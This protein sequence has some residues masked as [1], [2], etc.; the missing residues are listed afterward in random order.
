MNCRKTFVLSL[1]VF[2]GFGSAAFAQGQP[3]GGS[4]GSGGGS[5]YTHDDSLIGKVEFGFNHD[6]VVPPWYEHRAD[7]G[8]TAAPNPNIPPNP[9]D[10][11]ETDPYTYKPNNIPTDLM[12][13]AVVVTNINDSDSDG[14]IDAMDCKPFFSNVGEPPSGPGNHPRD[15]GGNGFSGTVRSHEPDLIKLTVNARDGV[16]Y[17][18][19]TPPS[20]GETRYIGNTK[21][22]SNALSK[23]YLWQSAQKKV[24][25]G[26]FGSNSR[27]APADSNGRRSSYEFTSPGLKTVYVEIVETSPTLENYEIYVTGP[28]EEKYGNAAVGIQ[29]QLVSSKDPRD[30]LS[31]TAIWGKGESGVLTISRK[32]YR[33]SGPVINGT[34]GGGQITFKSNAP[35]GTSINGSDSL[36][37]KGE[38]FVVYDDDNVKADI[39]LKPGYSDDYDV[40]RQ[41]WDFKVK[42]SAF[43]NGKIVVQIEETPAQCPS[44]VSEDDTVC[45]SIHAEVD[46]S[47]IRDLLQKYCG[48]CLGDKRWMQAGAWG[49]RVSMSMSPL[50]I[51][52]TKLSTGKH[53]TFDIT[54]QGHGVGH[55]RTDLALHKTFER[56]K[57][58]HDEKPND[59]IYYND[60][61]DNDVRNHPMNKLFG[62]GAQTQPPTVIVDA[63]R[64]LNFDACYA[65]DAPGMDFASDPEIEN[66]RYS[67]IKFL[68]GVYRCNFNEFIRVD[69]GGGKV[70]NVSETELVGR[71]VDVSR[72]TDKLKWHTSLARTSDLNKPIS[73][74]P[75]PTRYFKKGYVPGNSSDSKWVNVIGAGHMREEFLLEIPGGTKLNPTLNKSYLPL[76]N[77]YFN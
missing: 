52:R 21:I 56:I 33:I 37:K 25:Y 68:W 34:N 1:I 74:D 17:N 19:N 44:W 23:I 22:S 53:A 14:I 42:S 20:S 15:S 55:T 67:T 4:G 66:D 73:N 31:M 47:D 39:Y 30:R 49:V 10:P 62:N 35:D 11:K 72:C 29:P 13:G 71:W 60:D 8:S 59:E 64:T 48:H 26:G 45:F 69:F 41:H 9:N 76:D 54:R 75:N 6:I 61:N 7:F 32:P 3:S 57:P 50:G 46:R 24:P 43:V 28:R 16:I 5:V 70:Q 65:V 2:L 38:V 77:D 58:T 51:M 40:A 27:N 12:C 36:P 63:N 18:P